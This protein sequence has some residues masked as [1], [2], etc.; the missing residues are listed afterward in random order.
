MMEV[1]G[2]ECGWRAAER[3]WKEPSGWGEGPGW[4]KLKAVSRVA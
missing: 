4:V 1:G 2:W 3:G